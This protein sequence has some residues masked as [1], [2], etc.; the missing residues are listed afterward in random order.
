MLF[1]LS[2]DLKGIHREI[3]EDGRQSYHSGYIVTP[4]K[5]CSQGV[6]HS[7]NKERLHCGAANCGQ[8]GG[9]QPA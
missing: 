8:E 3:N 5:I 4:C 1:D 9:S 6:I 2:D 7:K